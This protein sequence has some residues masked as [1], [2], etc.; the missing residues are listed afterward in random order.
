MGGT[1][2]YTE[3]DCMIDSSYTDEQMVQLLQDNCPACY[4]TYVDCA[5][6]GNTPDNSYTPSTTTP[7]SSSCCGPSFLLGALSLG[8]FIIGRK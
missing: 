4:N 2:S 8:A 3:D 6:N 1:W 5:T 7:S